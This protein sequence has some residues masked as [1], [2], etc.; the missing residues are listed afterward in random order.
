[1][2]WD[3]KFKLTIPAS[4]VDADLTAFPFAVVLS[5]A[6]GTADFDASEIF[7]D[8]GENKYKIKVETA[9]ATE[10]Y[11][12]VDTWDSAAKFGVIY[13]K[14]DLS[15]T[16]DNVFYLF[17]D[18]AAADN[19]SYVGSELYPSNVA[20]ELV[21]D[22]NFTG[23]FHLS[24]SGLYASCKDSSPVN[25]DASSIDGITTAGIVDAPAG[26][27]YTFNGTSG[28]IT[29]SNL[30]CIY[31]YSGTVEM[32]FKIPTVNT[33]Y[34]ETIFCRDVGT[35]IYTTAANP[36][37]LRYST[38]S[39]LV[40]ST[41]PVRD[42][43]WH[44]AAC[45]RDDAATQLSV[46]IDDNGVEAQDTSYMKSSNDSS[47]YPVI[48]AQRQSSTYNRY[49]NGYV[50]EIRVS[51]VA[52]SDAWL[53][54]T[55][56]SLH[57]S[58]VTVSVEIIL[59]EVTLEI[60]TSGFTPYG[61]DCDVYLPTAELA[62]DGTASFGLGYP[63]PAG[64]AELTGTAGINIPAYLP[65]AGLAL[66]GTCL[67]DIVTVL[68]AVDLAIS[69]ALTAVVPGDVYEIPAV[70]L[71]ASGSAGAYMS[72]GF[73]ADI[74]MPAFVLDASLGMSADCAVSGVSAEGMLYGTV[75]MELEA[76]LRK[77]EVSASFG[78]TGE[79]DLSALGFVGEMVSGGAFS[80]EVFSRSNT[81][82]S[83]PLFGCLFASDLFVT[84]I[85]ADGAWQDINLFSLEIDVNS[86]VLLGTAYF[87]GALFTG[88]NMLETAEAVGTVLAGSSY[89]ADVFAGGVDLLGVLAYTVTAPSGLLQFHRGF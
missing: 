80:L 62:A 23:V 11:V 54:A 24:K 77:P 61:G 29:L 50:S 47:Y 53:K 49:L 55:A 52:R 38:L 2:A 18:A 65:A 88:D 68:P 45:R 17:Y 4:A 33:S 36:S 42:G 44:Y 46:T 57:D 79:A 84:R 10:C 69:G 48:G 51:K 30:S 85:T 58:L 89:S 8:L 73:T 83:T 5:S 37:Y 39:Q 81:L 82:D 21:W 3:K 12:E 70:T 87:N 16:V 75:V 64:V 26:R 14:A 76:G 31:P 32:F 13:V 15:S 28:R 63:L 60:T 19:T 66:S 43:N 78:M 41:T 59:P 6:C 56:L 22:S 7:T 86:S 35:M 67:V 34:E 1:M 71:N 25:K 20:A 9:A 27:G 74:A 40:T 72:G